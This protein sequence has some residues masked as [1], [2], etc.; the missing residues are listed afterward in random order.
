[1][2][3]CMLPSFFQT[4][5]TA[6]A[7]GLQDFLIAPIC[8]ISCKCFFISSNWSGRIC[9]YLSLKGVGLV[10]FM[11]CLTTEVFPRLRSFKAKRNPNSVIKLLTSFC[12]W[13]EQLTTPKR[14]TL[15]NSFS[16]FWGKSGTFFWKVKFLQRAK[17]ASRK[18]KNKILFFLK[19]I[20]S[21]RQK[22]LLNTQSLESPY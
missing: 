1:M 17:F 12:S 16:S 21:L 11:V 18:A 8:S 7:N 9:L 15:L 2:Q 3:K 10:S 13:T 22:Y 19:K 20:Y 6:L 4:R 14:S 5:T